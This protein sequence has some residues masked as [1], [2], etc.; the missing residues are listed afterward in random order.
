[1]G[2]YGC[3]DILF[4]GL[5]LWLGPVVSGCYI[6]LKGV[7]LTSLSSLT[8]SYV[9]YFFKKHIKTYLDAPKTRKGRKGTR[10]DKAA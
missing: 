1:M 10:S 9:S 4:I 6:I 2:L 5:P 3:R 7:F 8:A